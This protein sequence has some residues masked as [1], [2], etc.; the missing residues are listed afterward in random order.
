VPENVA[1]KRIIKSHSVCVAGSTAYL[2]VPLFFIDL[3]QVSCSG[4]AT[5][6]V[7]RAIVSK[8]PCSKEATRTQE[9]IMANDKT[10][11]DDDVVDTTELVIEEEDDDLDPEVLDDGLDIDAVEEFNEDDFDEDFDDDFEEEIVGEYDLADDQ[12]G[13]EFDDQFGHITNPETAEA[14]KAAQDKAV[15]ETAATK[16]TSK[17]APAKAEAKS[18]PK[19]AT[20]TAK[21]AKAAKAAKKPPARKK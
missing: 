7:L 8:I 10:E 14:K 2:S 5:P 20:K 18:T 11:E 1:A 15:V 16:K 4:A 17:K 12:Y 9:H 21:P 19:T 6:I 3:L 13:K